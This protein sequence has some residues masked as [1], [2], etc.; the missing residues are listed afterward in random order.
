MMSNVFAVCKGL[1]ALT[2]FTVVMPALMAQK[3]TESALPEGWRLP[4][5][6]EI[7]SAWRD[8][9]ST[10]FAVVKADFDGD[11]KID[12]AEILIDAATRRFGVFVKLAAA[13]Q[14]QLLTDGDLDAIDRF[15]IDRVKPGRYETACGKGY[16]DYA[17]ANGEPDFLV[18]KHAGLDFIYT[19]SSDTI[20]YWDQHSRKFLKALMSD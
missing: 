6:Q 14:W 4:T 10:R 15:A 18:L 20:F 2:I 17:C 19:E 8:K 11:G 16:G 7:A 9:S 3:P 5:K 12:I 13:E 1:I